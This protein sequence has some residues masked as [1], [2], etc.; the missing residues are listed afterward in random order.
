M[1]HR[2]AG[3]ELGSYFG[4]S[5]KSLGGFKR[6]TFCYKKWN[7]EKYTGGGLETEVMKPAYHS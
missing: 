5:R 3:Q 6:G 2:E 7:V 4:C 1:D